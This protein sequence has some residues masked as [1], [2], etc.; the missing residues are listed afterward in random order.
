MK[1]STGSRSDRS[2]LWYREWRVNRSLYVVAPFLMAAPWLLEFYTA[3]HPWTRYTM[4]FIRGIML[5][6]T[7]PNEFRGWDYII[8][9][10]LGVAVLWRDRSRLAALLDG[11]V[12][13]RPALRIKTQ[14]VLGSVFAGWL[15]ELGVLLVMGII[16]GFHDWSAFSRYMALIGI[17]Q[18]VLASAAL[19]ASVMAG[20]LL[21]ALTGA[22]VIILGPLVIGS[23]VMAVGS[24]IGPGSVTM[25][26]ASSLLDHVSPF[27]YGFSP[28]LALAYIPVYTAECVALWGLAFRWWSSAPWEMFSEPLLFSGAWNVVY[29]ILAA[30]TGG[31]VTLFFR[32]ASSPQFGSIAVFALSAVVAWFVWR[33]L[34]QRFRMGEVATR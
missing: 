19:T 34:F 21:F 22:A 15:L 31:T 11:P 25:A 6:V 29:G 24:I 4:M 5:R 26:G 14:F 9:G 13:R 7:Y 16:S 12:P 17:S 2:A 33:A 18:L 23:A 32:P 1:R 20:N 28:T 3:T 8:A 10:L 27:A 30:L